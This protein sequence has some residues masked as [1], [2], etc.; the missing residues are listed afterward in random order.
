MHIST[1][2]QP[3]NSTLGLSRFIPQAL[4]AGALSIAVINYLYYRQMLKRGALS[5]LPVVMVVVNTR[6]V[7][8]VNGEL[9]MSKRIAPVALVISVLASSTALAGERTITLAV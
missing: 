3:R 8:Q 9:P 5:Y 1:Q 6:A 7:F 2:W 4:A